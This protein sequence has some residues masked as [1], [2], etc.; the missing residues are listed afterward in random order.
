MHT[1]D[2]TFRVRKAEILAKRRHR[3]LVG[4]AFA[5]GGVLAVALG[6]G[7]WLTA[8]KW[9]VIPLDEEL[10]EV[11]SE[12]V[13]QNVPVF[14]PTTI[15]LA[16]DPMTI[17]IGSA[18]GSGVKQ[19]P[20]P[21]TLVEPGISPRLNLLSQ[22]MLSTSESLMTTI[23]SSPED[24]A[25]F[26]AQ[27]AVATALPADP[28]SV[29]PPTASTADEAFSDPAAGWGE[30][31]DEGTEALPTFQRTRIENNTSVALVVPEQERR[32][33]AE[34]FVDRVLGPRTLAELAASHGIDADDAGK[35]AD[36]LKTLLG[37]EGFGP[38]HIVAMRAAHPGPST[39]QPGG[40][41][42]LVQLSVYR[43]ASYVGTLA[44]SADGS[45]VQG[46]DPWVREDL[47][48]YSGTEQQ[49][50]PGRQYRLLDAVYSTAARNGVPTGVI[51]EA[52]MF[53]SRGQDLNAFATYG[54]RF[55]LIWSETGRGE[56]GAS[57]RVLYTAIQG[58]QKSVE[59]FVF[60]P[61]NTPDFAC[62]TETDQVY[63][64][65]VTN[66]MVTP[67]NGV[68]TSTFGPR[69]HPI[70]N[71]LRVHKGVDW[72]APVGTP[73]MAAF[74]GKVVFRGDGEGYGNVV[75]L[76]HADG[77]E[78]RYAHLSAF[79]RGLEVGGAVKAGD[80]IGFVGTTGLSTG[81][82]LHFE[83]YRGGDAVNPLE[84]VQVAA[85]GDGS[86]AVELLVDRIVHVES[87]GSAT[88][89]N[90]LSTATGLGQF[91]ESTWIRM[92]NTYRPDL[93]RS[94]TR[95]E[96]LKLRFEPTISR[97]MVRRLALEG[98]AYLRARGHAITAGRLY[99][100][101]FLGMEGASVVLSSP[102]DA[103]LLPVLGQGVLSANPF[104]YGKTVADLKEWAERKMRNRGSPAAPS[105]P[106]VETRDVAR[107]SPEFQA[108]K[109]AISALLA[110]AT[111]AAA[112]G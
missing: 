107:A 69:R 14:V 92:I 109:A 55:V 108:Y 36:A 4:A 97:E 56:D 105:A 102:D 57:G 84:S 101:H 46:V 45:F 51:G 98:E 34:D 88:A 41:L 76:S 67:V 87:G 60:R 2:P 65:T 95:E 83:L 63:S 15:D 68:M 42:H 30:T 21:E 47:L 66:G 81:P 32:P 44:R 53:L 20:R 112:P 43:D 52:I 59:C 25:Y 104:L 24:F 35:A 100:C 27:R 9:S 77:S 37:V 23:P 91:I 93:A 33:G 18:G 72:A 11:E 26:Q 94:L 39:S 38:G 111:A 106:Q 71:T 74:D 12:V 89:K 103:D 10:V 58:A 73:V 64:L 99:L 29:T 48:H 22:E 90:P 79:A 3:R 13:D 82:H 50:D 19:V 7:F 80:V 5:A 54:D 16:G 62:V 75:R 8:D 40:P 61:A 1:I 17:R 28:L 31:L 110:S 6:V 96:I 49:A 78:T 70:L 85:S 86:T